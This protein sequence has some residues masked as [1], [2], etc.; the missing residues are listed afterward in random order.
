M[1]KGKSNYWR[2]KS[3]T[4]NLPRSVRE[5]NKNGPNN[6]NDGILNEL[7]V[8]SDAVLATRSRIV[9]SPERIKRNIVTMSATALEDKRIVSTNEAKTRDLQAKISILFQVEKDVRVCIEALQAIQKERE[10][11]EA[12][13]KDLADGKDALD[14]KKMTKNE[15]ALKR[16]RV[17]KQ[18]FNAQEKLDRTIRQAHE[19]RH[20]SEQNI[21]RLQ[22]DYEEMVAARHENDKEVEVYHVQER[23]VQKM[24]AQHMKQSEIELDELLTEY[25]KLRH[26]ADVYMEIMSNK[27]ADS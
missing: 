25:W 22:T 21:E 13:L 12:S 9:Q 16:E 2:S 27:L 1:R 8:L 3:F 15:L 24:M 6:V 18:L 4:T 20:A 26:E 5:S 11:L 7:S 23:E 14:E 17:R 10:A 19:R